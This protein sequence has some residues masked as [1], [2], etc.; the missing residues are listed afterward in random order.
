MLAIA[1]SKRI[2][3]RPEPKC[4]LTT[5]KTCLFFPPNNREFEVGGG[6]N[7]NQAKSWERHKER[8]A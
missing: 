4:K 5:D 7:E 1:V 2:W 6:E 3:G 8:L